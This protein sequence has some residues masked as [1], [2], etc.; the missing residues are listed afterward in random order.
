LAVTLFALLSVSSGLVL[1]VAFTSMNVIEAKVDLDRRVS[2]T[3]RALEQMLRGVM[4]V[5]GTCGVAPIA[6][7]ATPAV[8]RFV[9]SYSLTEGSRGRPQIVEL[10]AE[11]KGEASGYRLVVNEY[12]YFGRASLVA[13]C[14]QPPVV[15]PSSFILADQLSVCRFFFKSLDPATGGETWIPQWMFPNWPRGIR[16]EMQPR[17]AGENRAQASTLSVPLLVRRIDGE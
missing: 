9:S 3:Q 14:S 12:P 7:Q 11:S 1:R 4:A 13:A 10:I 17:R 15:R 8:M 5:Q 6:F 16:I 2:G